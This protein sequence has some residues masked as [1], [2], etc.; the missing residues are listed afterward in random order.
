MTVRIFHDDAGPPFAKVESQILPRKYLDGLRSELRIMMCNPDEL[1]IST[2]G[3]AT[4]LLRAVEEAVAWEEMFD[5]KLATYNGRRALHREDPERLRRKFPDD[6]G[7]DA[8]ASEEYS[9]VMGDPYGGKLMT[10][11][12]SHRKAFYSTYGGKLEYPSQVIAV[13]IFD[14]GM[15]VLL[16]KL[17][18]CFCFLDTLIF[19]LS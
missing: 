15:Q 14:R 16:E 1:D 3:F 4:V 10:E 18:E 13:P 9:N 7:Y 17:I 6:H 11:D 19:K 12:T 5:R 2:F 8:Q